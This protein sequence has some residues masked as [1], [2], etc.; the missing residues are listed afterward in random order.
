MKGESTL[1]NAGS[2][3]DTR[4]VNYDHFASATTCSFSWHFSNSMQL[5]LQQHAP[6]A[7]TSATTCSFSLHFSNNMLL[8]LTLQQQHAAYTSATTYSFSLHFSNNILHQL[9]LQQ[10]HAAY[11]SVTTCS[12]SLHLRGLQSGELR[13]LSRLRLEGR[14]SNW[15]NY[16]VWLGVCNRVSNWILSS[17]QPHGVSSGQSN[18]VINYSTSQSTKPIPT[19]TSKKTYVHKHQIFWEL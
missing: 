13:S 7:Y 14:F 5:T 12:F 4:C 16:C 2:S 11:T 8:H 15:C 1:W 6:S 18:S 9:T 10:Q 17:C 19:Q 3:A